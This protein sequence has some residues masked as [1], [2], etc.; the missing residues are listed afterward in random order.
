[1]NELLI[2][3]VRFRFK[4]SE[5][6]CVVIIVNL[7]QLLL[8]ISKIWNSFIVVIYVSIGVKFKLIFIFSQQIWRLIFSI[9]NLL[10]FRRSIKLYLNICFLVSFLH[11]H[12]YL[13]FN[14]F[15]LLIFV[16]TFF[17]LFSLEII[18]KDVEFFGLFHFFLTL[19][20]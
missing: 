2:N 12:S 4:I 13:F 20:D 15:N 7:F 17:H 11:F 1:M 5:F 10:S 19:F 3:I 9:L 16:K 14:F 8:K 6:N 18:V